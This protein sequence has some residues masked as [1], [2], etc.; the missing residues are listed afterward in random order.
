MEVLLLLIILAVLFFFVMKDF[1][2]DI[3]SLKRN[4]ASSDF[5]S[6]YCDDVLEKEIRN[7]IRTDAHSRE[8]VWTEVS[9]VISSMSKWNNYPKERL[10]RFGFAADKTTK[11]YYGEYLA[12]PILMAQKGKI[13][14]NMGDGWSVSQSKTF[15]GDFRGAMLQLSRYLLEQLRRTYPDLDLLMYEDG[16]MCYRFY[17]SKNANV[18]DHGVSV[19]EIKAAGE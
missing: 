5:K 6:E 11:I 16:T 13:P 2:S 3:K 14:S 8:I 7:T 1:S 17:W 9:A 18:Y 19:N 12:I 15:P 4:Q 10:N